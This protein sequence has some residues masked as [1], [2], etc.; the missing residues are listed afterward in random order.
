MSKTDLGALVLSKW[1]RVDYG[2]QKEERKLSLTKGGIPTRTLGNL[3]KYDLDGDGVISPYELARAGHMFGWEK[4]HKVW[5]MGDICGNILQQMDDTGFG[6]RSEGSSPLNRTISQGLARDFVR[7]RSYCQ[8]PAWL[9]GGCKCECK[10]YDPQLVLP[11]SMINKLEI[12]MDVETAARSLLEQADNF[13]FTPATGFEEHEPLRS[14]DFIVHVEEI[15][16]PP[17]EVMRERR[18]S[19]AQGGR[20]ASMRP[21]VIG[22]GGPQSQSAPSGP[23][24][25]FFD[26]MAGHLVCF[27]LRSGKH[28]S[29][30]TRQERSENARNEVL[31]AEVN[32]KLLPHL[33][34]FCEEY[35]A[36]KVGQ[37]VEARREEEGDRSPTGA[38]KK[39]WI[40][41]KCTRNSIWI[42][43]P[44]FVRE[45]EE[46]KAATHPD[47][48]IERPRMLCRCGH[49]DLWHHRTQTE[50]DASTERS[51]DADEEKSESGN[52]V[53]GKGAGRSLRASAP[54]LRGN[55]EAVLSRGRLVLKQAGANLVRRPAG[56]AGGNHA[57]R[58]AQEDGADSPARQRQA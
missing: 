8:A 37:L 39:A 45:E 53:R 42:E 24:A 46:K 32:E 3:D 47:V 48:A 12:A 40:A 6:L 9:N 28:N 25:A 33:L 30:K 18:A 4:N 43:K 50:K 36:V 29:G 7:S 55:G 35:R 34:R 56:D 27:Q 52:L 51:E 54:Q 5:V 1:E 23:S 2:G 13:L 22:V 31:V 26:G 15:A 14:S 10:Q 38:S 58:N 41:P 17:P 57:R 11:L 49:A 21:S 44:W 20:R 16:K 19:T